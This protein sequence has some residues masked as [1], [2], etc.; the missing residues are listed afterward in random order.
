MVFSQGTRRSRLA[1]LLMSSTVAVGLEDE[2]ADAD[3]LDDGL[4]VLGVLLL[5]RPRPAERLRSPRPGT[6]R[7]SAKEAPSPSSL[8]LWEK[9]S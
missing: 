4:E 2:E 3:V 5:L 8:K 6:S 1:A 7:S 9:S